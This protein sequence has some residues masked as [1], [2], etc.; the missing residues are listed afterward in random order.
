MNAE[1][2]LL[3]N[4]TVLDKR[5]PNTIAS[6]DL[7]R[8]YVGDSL[9][10]LHIFEVVYDNEIK[11]TKIKSISHKKLEGDQINK[12]SIDPINK[13][14]LLIH[15]RDNSL[16]LINPYGKEAKL[17]IE[18]EF[19]GIKCNKTNIKSVISPDGQY[20]LSGSE[21]GIPKLWHLLTG[22]VID[23]SNNLETKFIDSVSDVSWNRHFN[24]IALSGFGQEYPVLLFF[25]EK[26]DR[27]VEEG[28]LRMNM[29]AYNRMDEN[30]NYNNNNNYDFE[31]NN[32]NY[33][34]SN[35]NDYNNNNNQ[36]YGNTQDNFGNSNSKG[37]YNNNSYNNTYNSNFN[38]D[39]YVNNRE[40]YDK[41]KTNE[42]FNNNIN[43]NLTNNN[44]Y[45]N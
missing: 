30:N 33:N 4:P 10:T 35:N 37:N 25:Y 11:V 22:F 29:N 31:G 21:E 23:R 14:K 6:D 45:N 42:N 18:V 26:T 1:N 28:L 41:T 16:R 43:E 15:S 34:Y 40:Y 8:V 44:N 32:T 9:G 2:E 38:K 24:V 19:K 5:F 20:I 27:E 13:Q 7:G 36:E 39:M 3:L 12:I 17:S